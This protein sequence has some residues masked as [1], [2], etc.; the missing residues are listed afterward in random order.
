MK[1]YISIHIMVYHI[2]IDVYLYL[3]LLNEKV[4]NHLIKHM[5]C[6]K[7]HLCKT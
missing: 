5:G 3:I 1:N 6:I 2:N 4:H 7:Y